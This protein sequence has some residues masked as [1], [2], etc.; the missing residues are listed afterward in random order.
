MT[1][2]LWVDDER[3]APDASWLTAR[4]VSQ[5][6]SALSAGDVAEVSLDH[7]LGGDERGVQITDWMA[8]HDAFPPVLHVHS[9]NPVGRE[10]M[11]AT[12]LRYGPYT[13]RIGATLR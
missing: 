2:R 9:A 3:A 4:T 5:A 13:R 8:E 11:L 6:L 7:D 1:V 10:Q 12:A